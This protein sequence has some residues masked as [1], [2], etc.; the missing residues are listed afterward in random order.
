MTSSGSQLLPNVIVPLIVG[1]LGF[2]GGIFARSVRFWL[3]KRTRR[4]KLRTALLTEIKSPERAINKMDK[5]SAD[6]ELVKSHTNLP[7]RVYQEHIDDVGLLARAEVEHVVDYYSIVEV[8]NSQLEAESDE[9]IESFLENTVPGL[10]NARDDAESIL[11]KHTRLLGKYRY[12]IE[13]FCS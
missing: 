2:M 3:E 7:D 4:S 5:T 10:K 8:A 6:T 12:K 9:R 13:Q 11:E 1:I